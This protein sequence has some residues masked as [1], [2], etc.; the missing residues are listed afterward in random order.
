MNALIV[1]DE[2][3]NR[4]TLHLLLEQNCPDVKV[5]AKAD[6][7]SSARQMLQGFKAEVIF[8]D[9]NMPNENGFDF[10]TSIAKENYAVVF[11]TAYEQYALKALKANAVDYLLKPVNTD[12]LKLAV[13]KV[14][15]I[16]QLKEASKEAGNVYSQS[17]QNLTEDLK[18]KRWPA[19]LTLSHQHG[20]VI[21]D[22]EDIV[23]LEADGN[24]SIIHL[25]SM[26]KLVVTR[27]IREFEDMLDPE[28]FIRIHK[29]I[30]INL[31]YLQEYSREEGNFAV[32]KDGARVMVSRRKLDEFMEAVDRLAR[33]V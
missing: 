21:V 33:K 28:I 26:Q 5:V 30:I 7:A 18:R 11:V 15:Y 3:L 6:S 19:K 10:L 1:D 29:S 14:K 24:Y 20:F 4:E 32:M 2:K 12:E 31:R 13:E 25:S 8:L 27:P 9:I 23:Y 22:T 16:L 17:L